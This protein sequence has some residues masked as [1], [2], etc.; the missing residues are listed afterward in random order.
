MCVCM[1][2][3]V[4][5]TDDHSCLTC[6]HGVVFGA[7]GD[8]K[9]E[10]LMLMSRSGGALKQDIVGDL[11]GV[12]IIDFGLM[13]AAVPAASHGLSTRSAPRS[14][15]GTPGYYAPES[16]LY[17]EY[18]TASDIWQLG[19]VLYS[20]LSGCSPFHPDH[21][22]QTI[23]YPF[24]EMSGENWAGI[25]DSAKDL[26]R[27]LLQKIPAKRSQLS[28]VLA[29]PWLQ[30]SAA[31][32]APCRTPLGHGYIARIHRLKIRQ[33]LKQAFLDEKIVKSHRLRQDS[34]NGLRNA[35][36]STDHSSGTSEKCHVDCEHE[37]NVKRAKRHTEMDEVEER[38]W[39][40][41]K[42]MVLSARTRL[43]ENKSSSLD[44]DS[45]RAVLM[46]C[47]LSQWATPE[48]F[49]LF[50]I[51]GT[52]M[53]NLKEFLLSLLALQPNRPRGSSLGRRSDESN[54]R[55][56]DKGEISHVDV[57]DS[58]WLFFSLFDLN[59]TGYIDIHELRLVVD[60]F[61]NADQFTTNWNKHACSS[62]S[63]SEESTDWA[64]SLL[65]AIDT[66][67]SGT[68]DFHEFKMFYET[69]F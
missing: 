60:C 8:L 55:K 46:E 3:C 7:I 47:E 11:E 53:V 17:K 62:Y 5:S 30:Y 45:F 57:E 35:C 64:T 52:G 42:K 32:D 65:T 13:T 10:N 16:L 66:S 24:F 14:L 41:M 6:Y 18:S 39:Q 63:H 59:S 36:R 49:R 56:E 48:C 33:Q 37:N 23:F 69:A 1:C 26:V 67:K 40:G 44:Y 29:H 50:D 38:K 43:F 19:C 25:S 54:G 28:E 9:L 51:D 68:I 34:F 22:D 12:K 4:A 20:L 31:V 2:M 15:C 21:P 27:K 61:I 58:A